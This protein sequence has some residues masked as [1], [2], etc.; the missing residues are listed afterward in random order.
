MYNDRFLRLR[1][2]L[3]MPYNHFWPALWCAIKIKL[4]PYSFNVFLDDLRDRGVNPSGTRFSL[5]NIG[6]GRCCYTKFPGNSRLVY[7]GAIKSIVDLLRRPSGW[8]MGCR[9]L[10]HFFYSP[11]RAICFYF[12][13][14][15]IMRIFLNVKIILRFTP[16]KIRILQIM[17]Y[18]I[19][20][21]KKLKCIFRFT[22]CFTPF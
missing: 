19:K 4:W 18:V 20:Y 6:N 17:F 5:H 2:S 11:C 14:C 10:V 12:L 7:P 1:C 15:L 13:D 3:A 22:P 8:F 16:K 21:I 9:C